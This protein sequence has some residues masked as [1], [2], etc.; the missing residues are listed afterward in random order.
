MKHYI[1]N[2]QEIQRNLST[3]ENGTTIEAISSNLDDKV[4]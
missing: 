4:N 3:N 1:V 2:E